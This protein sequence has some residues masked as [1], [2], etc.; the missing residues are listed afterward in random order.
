[1]PINVSHKLLLVATGDPEE[2]DIRPKIRLTDLPIHF[3][4]GL[5]TAR[6]PWTRNNE[7]PKKKA[8]TT[9]SMKT[10]DGHFFTKVWQVVRKRMKST[11][12]IPHQVVQNNT[13][14]PE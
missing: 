6:L 2:H 5:L 7:T 14:N 11:K 8:I 9:I 13:T 3:T 10:R 12:D 4:R 1:M